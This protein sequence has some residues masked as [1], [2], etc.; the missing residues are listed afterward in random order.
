M[1]AVSVPLN[2]NWSTYRPTVLPCRPVL[3][4]TLVLGERSTDDG[5]PGLKQGDVLNITNGTPDGRLVYGV[6]RTGS[7]D[8]LRE[9]WL[10]ADAVRILGAAERENV[11]SDAILPF[12]DVLEH[13]TLVC[14]D[15]DWADLD[16]DS[17]LWIR[18]G[19]IIQVGMVKDA[20]VYGWLLDT[21]SRPGWFPAAFAHTVPTSMEMLAKVEEEELPDNSVEHLADLIKSMPPPSGMDWTW[22]GELPAIV[23][24]SAR[25]LEEEWHEKAQIA[26][27]EAMA[28]TELANAEVQAQSQHHPAG[29]AEF[30]SD[31]IHR[32]GDS[33]RILVEAPPE[34]LYPLVVCKTEFAVP[35]AV[36]GELLQLRVG[37]LV[38]VTSILETAMY[39]GFLEN[40]TTTRGWF[41]KNCV[42]LV[43]DP[44]DTTLENQ[45]S[46]LGPPPLPVVPAHLRRQL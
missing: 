31:A 34:E 15:E 29:A 3:A 22:E 12:N 8:S 26:A 2:L 43:E 17:T 39:H 44:L 33:N 19:D 38:R 11:P 45:P 20:W 30:A 13:T 9:G 35:G 32:G 1:E 37:D 27:E 24:D 25:E 4:Q 36:N 5:I 14:A 10:K 21:P 28:Q 41:P 42:Q 40:K 46:L 6:A 16:E 23:A 18:S 7:N